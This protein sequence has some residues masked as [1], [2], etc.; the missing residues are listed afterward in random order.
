MYRV[1]STF[2]IPTDKVSISSLNNPVLVTFNGKYTYSLSAAVSD[3][4]KIQAGVYVIIP[5]TFDANQF[6][7]FDIVI[8]STG[9]FIETA[10][11]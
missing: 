4:K 1:N 8:Y 10:P 7:S 11:Y 5:T 3:K 9:N 6:A 2:P